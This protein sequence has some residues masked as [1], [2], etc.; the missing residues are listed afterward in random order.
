MVL[1]VAV[2]VKGRIGDSF[3]AD[4]DVALFDVHHS[5]FDSFR[6]L[7]SLHD[8]RQ[9]SSTKVS[10]IDFFTLIEPLSLIN[11]PHFIQFV[12]KLSRFGNPIC[13]TLFQDNKFGYQLLYLTHNLIIFLIVVSV[14]NVI[15]PDDVHFAHV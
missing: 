3:D 9:P 5:L 14:L 12:D 2:H 10:N 7:Q 15:S 8:N 13:I 4:L 1:H 11:Q 6:H